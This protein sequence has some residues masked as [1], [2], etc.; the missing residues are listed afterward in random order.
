MHINPSWA[1]GAVTQ[2]LDLKCR[3]VIFNYINWSCIIIKRK[4]E[5]SFAKEN[6]NRF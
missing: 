5:F 2:L 1:D 3:L 4:N 6:F